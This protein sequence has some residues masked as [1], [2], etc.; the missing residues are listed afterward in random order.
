MSF[1]YS[2]VAPVDARWIAR[3]PAYREPPPV[4]ELRGEYDRA[5]VMRSLDFL[6][7]KPP[8]PTPEAMRG[9]QMSGSLDLARLV[10]HLVIDGYD[11]PLRRWALE[12]GRRG[13]NALYFAAGL[14]AA[15]VMTCVASLWTAGS[16][17]S[18][19]IKVVTGVILV[20]AVLVLI[21]ALS[22][23][24]PLLAASAYA[25]TWVRNM[26]RSRAAPRYWRMYEEPHPGATRAHEDAGSPWP[27]PQ[28]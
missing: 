7:P 22:R 25:G 1:C 28:R 5:A 20:S 14:L 12:R 23:I 16:A 15:S 26:P 10:R 17:A 4:W 21:Y 13:M 27:N 11:R 6:T 19:A 8:R 24:L 18:G 2:S 9:P 3:N